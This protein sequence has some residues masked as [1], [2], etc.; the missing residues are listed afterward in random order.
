MLTSTLPGVGHLAPPGQ[1]AVERGLRPGDVVNQQVADLGWRQAVVGNEGGVG[2]LEATGAGVIFS[3]ALVQ[4]DLLCCGCLPRPIRPHSTQVQLYVEASKAIMSCS[5]LRRARP[6]P[7]KPI[8]PTSSAWLGGS[9]N[10]RT[11]PVEGLSCR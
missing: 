3:R 1:V 8:I 10:A 9:W 4:V 11:E 5:S 2:F 6:S 7:A